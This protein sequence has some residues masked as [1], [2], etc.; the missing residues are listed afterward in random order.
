MDR[1]E[2]LTVPKFFDRTEV[3]NIG[4]IYSEEEDKERKAGDRHILH[5]MVNIMNPEWDFRRSASAARLDI[6]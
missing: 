6:L 2:K 5:H 3:R 1:F 4:E